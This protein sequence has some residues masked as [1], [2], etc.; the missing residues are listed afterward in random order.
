MNLNLKQVM[1]ISIAILGVLMISTTNLTD[2]FGPKVAK[3]VVSAAAVLNSILGSIMAVITS[4][5]GTIKDVAAMADDPNS[6][7]KGLITTNT[8]EGRALAQSIPQNT[9]VSA[10]T[11][12][13][14][15][16]AKGNV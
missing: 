3:T 6:A 1:A 11:T 16:L 4:T 7:V 5:T 9:V 2:L 15:Q 10:G 12:E 14:T 8:I 13:A